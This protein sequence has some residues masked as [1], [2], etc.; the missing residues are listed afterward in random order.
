MP[1]TLTL[2]VIIAVVLICN[3]RTPDTRVIIRLLAV[4]VVF[5]IA[6]TVVQQKH[7]N[8]ALECDKLII[9]GLKEHNAIMER[10]AVIQSYR[11]ELEHGSTNLLERIERMF[12]PS[13]Y[14]SES[15]GGYQ[16]L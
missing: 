13:D 1:L 10:M 9:N 12:N 14:K 3:K 4:L 15:S 7:L 6:S 2:L 5:N 8:H 11:Y 16:D